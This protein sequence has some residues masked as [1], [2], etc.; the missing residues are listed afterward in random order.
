[1]VTQSGACRFVGLGKHERK[2]G[3]TRE[4]LIWCF[5]LAYSPKLWH[6]APKSLGLRVKARILALT[7][8]PHHHGPQVSTLGKEGK[9]EPWWMVPCS[10]RADTPASAPAVPAPEW[11]GWS[12]SSLILSFWVWKMGLNYKSCFLGL[13]RQFLQTTSRGTGMS[14]HIVLLG[15]YLLD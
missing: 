3:V 15:K 14:Q 9:R 13:L 5:S 10:S 12:H 4:R 11:T 8:P 7:L 1:M 6:K 2:E